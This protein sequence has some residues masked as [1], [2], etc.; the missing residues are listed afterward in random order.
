MLLGV[1]TYISVFLV[2]GF[3]LFQLFLTLGAPIGEYALGGKYR[4]LPTKMRIVSGFFSGL[5]FTVGF[6]FMQIT[7]QID[8]VFNRTFVDVLLIVYTV[9]LAY[10]II[11]NGFI[12][13]SKKEK[14][15]MTPL[16]IIGFISSLFV[17]L[18]H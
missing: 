16:S 9:F 2:F 13:K 17:L 14:Y 7:G 8:P 12:T 6:S 11:G 18:N 10:A 4:I 15:V 3:A 5:W 1:A